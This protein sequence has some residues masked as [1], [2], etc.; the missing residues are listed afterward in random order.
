MVSQ[1]T[2]D[3]ITEQAIDEVMG[4]GRFGSRDELLREAVRLIRVREGFDPE[5]D[6]GEVDDAT[7]EAVERGVADVR[8]GR[9]RPVADVF[10]DLRRRYQP[11]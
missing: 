2:L 5:L 6:R 9:A 11:D 4:L 3:P 10:R 1:L 8:A 7:R